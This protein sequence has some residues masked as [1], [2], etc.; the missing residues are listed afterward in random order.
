MK[1]FIF[2]CLLAV[3]L[4]KPK[5]EQ[6]SSEETIAVSQE[7]SPNL[8]NICSTACEEPIKN[9]NEVE[10]VEVPTEIK[11]QEFYQKVNLL[12]YL[13]ALYQYPT[14]MDPW[15]RAETKAIPFIRTM[16]YKQEK[17]AT[18]HTSQKTELTE[19][20]KA[21]LKYLDEMKQYYQK[22]V[23]PQYLKNAHHFQKTMNPWN[24]VKT[25]I[26]QSVPTLRYL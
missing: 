21:F 12:Q 16:Q 1:F 4:A 24:H 17:D 9:I 20:E 8:E 26:Y 14:V 19:E 5:I 3:A 18:K 15:T 13:Q 11:D 23:F 6:S 7:V 25:I 2:T 10:Y 22:F